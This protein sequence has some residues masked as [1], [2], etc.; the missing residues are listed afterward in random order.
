M[1]NTPGQFAC[2]RFHDGA[3]VHELALHLVVHPQRIAV[4]GLGEVKT[5][6]LACKHT[7]AHGP[8]RRIQEII[9]LKMH[10]IETTRSPARRGMHDEVRSRDQ[11]LTID[12]DLHAVRKAVHVELER[13]E[14]VRLHRQQAHTRELLRD[15]IRGQA[16]AIL[17][18]SA[19]MQRRCGEVLH[20]L[21]RVAADDIGFLG[22]DHHRGDHHE[23]KERS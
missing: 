18:I 6:G 13:L 20:V 10:Q 1:G 9:R 3:E 8:A 11:T 5:R 14:V 2:C 15:P 4:D 16:V 17:H 22:V 7:H 19:T 12:A 23:E 21:A